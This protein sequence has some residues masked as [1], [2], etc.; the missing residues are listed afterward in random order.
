MAKVHTYT[1][2]IDNVEINFEYSD[3]RTLNSLIKAL[4]KS[5]KVTMKS[6][7]ECPS[8]KVESESDFKGW[9]IHEKYG[10]VALKPPENHSKEEVTINP[11]ISVEWCPAL[12][13]KYWNDGMYHFFPKKTKL[14]SEFTNEEIKNNLLLLGAEL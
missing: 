7:L 3:K 1:Y 8:I 13:G 11:T 2:N 14:S 5:T 6:K 12:N 4:E 9:T 10:H